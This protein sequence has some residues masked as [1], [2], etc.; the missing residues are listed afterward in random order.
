ML[1]EPVENSRNPPEKE[2]GR[3][4]EGPARARSTR[5]P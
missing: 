3:K 5:L 1:K 2:V 4:N